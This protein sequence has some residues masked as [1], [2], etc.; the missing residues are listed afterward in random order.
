MKRERIKVEKKEER[1]TKRGKDCKR[2][3]YIYIYI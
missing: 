3:R 2:V 1:K